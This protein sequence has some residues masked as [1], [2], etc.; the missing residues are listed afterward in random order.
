MPDVPPRPADSA[1]R[2]HS[3]AAAVFILIALVPFIGLTAT[4]GFWIANPLRF[5][6]RSVLH[7]T[8]TRPGDGARSI[9][10]NAFVAAD[11][12]LP[13]KGKGVDAK[14]ITVDSVKL[15]RAADRAP[16]KATINT[17]GAGD[18][19]VLQPA[20]LLE[21]ETA[22]TFE[23]TTSLKDT[24]GTPFHPY[25]STFT[26]AAGAA[27]SDYPIA[28]EKVPLG[29]S[30][31]VIICLALG[32]DGKL[33]GGTFDGR[34]LRYA[35]ESDG[36]LGP[37]Q[38]IP[39]IQRYNQGPRLITGL[40]FDPMAPPGELVLWVS[41]G[42]MALEKAPNWSGK[43]S[44]L[45]GADLQ[46]CEDVVINLPRAY[47]DH[48]NNQLEFGPDGAIYFNQA[49]MTATG[50]PDRKWNMRPETYLTAAMLRL[51]P[52]L[53]KGTLDAKSIAAPNAS[54]GEG[55][56][57]TVYATGVR[58]AF[59]LLFHSNGVLYVPINGSA[60]GGNTPANKALSVQGIEAVSTQPDLL[61]RVEKGGYYGHPNPA[62]GEYVLNGGN[63]T[64]GADPIEVR[65]YRIGTKPQPN[66]RPPAYDF[67]KSVSPNGVI[68]YKS[69]AFNGQL[70]GKL[71]VTRY[72]GGDDVI[73]LTPGAGGNI[74]ESVSG[75]SG[76]GGF[77]DPL[78][79]LEDPRTGNL[80]VAEFGGQ[81]LTLLRPRPGGFSHV[82][83]ERVSR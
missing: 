5:N 69:A 24:A 68:E 57:L 60:H 9:L 23:V 37:G 53:I 33:Y 4:M 82:F 83:R 56:P 31:G 10:P 80:Y 59:D 62:R 70:R 3:S 72:S 54:S 50:A 38:V 34:I 49:S 17:S 36:T 35:I 22:Y 73:I 65:E 2:V 14:S 19:I 21:P 7:V 67:G 74:A 48:L 61:L 75:V 28:F 42:A 43:I 32:P 46:A 18:A 12:Y 11:V 47:R 16:V 55:A 78:D 66:W 79:L 81:K 29:Q 52:R 27:T 15:Y 13:N 30:E 25:T 51:D 77:I 39:T 45:R 64:D 76:L 40:R 71:L 1:R 6:P 20:Q 8:G 58:V 63:P 44:R 26:T 41:H